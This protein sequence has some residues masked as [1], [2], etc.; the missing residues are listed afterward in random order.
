MITSVSM[1]VPEMFGDWALSQKNSKK[2]C[3]SE[4]DVYIDTV[5]TYSLFQ[6]VK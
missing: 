4:S 6:A 5:T 2:K 1:S 3:S